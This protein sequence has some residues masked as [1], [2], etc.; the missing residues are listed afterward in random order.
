M[1][2]FTGVSSLVPVPDIPLR[3]NANGEMEFNPEATVHAH[4]GE[5]LVAKEGERNQTLTRLCGRM[6]GK[7]CGIE[8]VLAFAYGWNAKF[9]VPPLGEREIETI[10]RSMGET[11]ARKNP[12]ALNSGGV[13]RWVSFAE[14]EFTIADIY[15]DLK[16]EKADG[17]DKCQQEIRELV[18]SGVLETS[19]GR[20][21]WYRRCEKKLETIDLNAPELPA[22]GLWLPFGLHRDVVVQPKNVI[23]VAGETNSGKTGLMFNLAFMNMGKF[24]VRYLSSEMT[25][26]EI[27]TRMDFFGKERAAWNSVEFI[28]RSGNFHDAIDPN[29]INIIDF[30]EVHDNFFSIGADIKKI[31]DALK[32]GVAVIAIQKRTGELFGRG[33]E[34][35]LEKARL[36]LSLFTHG[37]LPNGII[38]SVKVTKAKNYIQGR[39]PDGKE[40]FYSLARGYFYDDAPL[41]DVNYKRGLRF[42]NKRERNK[43]ISEIETYCKRATEEKKADE[44]A[45][46]YGM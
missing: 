23:I 43:I 42:Y 2:G 22:V 8:E 4:S 40:Q 14:G 36:G 1:E 44:M 26:K 37:R 11:H 25:A 9:C 41:P 33:G 10:V 7:G 28:E 18:K 39:N 5:S 27:C 19:R 35:T 29:G 21:G 15:R 32:N 17:R 20:S 30:L 12:Q 34:F 16:I 31:F 3:K 24:P 13:T 6:Y 45:N 38:G 46:F